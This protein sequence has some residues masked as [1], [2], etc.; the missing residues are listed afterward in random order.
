MAST[1]PYLDFIMEQL[2]EEERKTI[3]EKN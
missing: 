2:P 3:S 1:K